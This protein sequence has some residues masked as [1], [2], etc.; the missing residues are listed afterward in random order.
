MSVMNNIRNKKM[1]ET[2]LYMCTR[3][4]LVIIIMELPQ[5]YQMGMEILRRFAISAATSNT[6]DAKASMMFISASVKVMNPGCDPMHLLQ[7]IRGIQTIGIFDANLEIAEKRVVGNAER[8]DDLH[9]GMGLRVTT[10]VEKDAIV[11]LYPVDGVGYVR[12]NKE[13]ENS[14]EVVCRFGVPLCV[15]DTIKDDQN[16]Y[17]IDLTT[18]DNPAMKVGQLDVKNIFPVVSLP[19]DKGYGGFSVGGDKYHGHMLNDYAVDLN[20]HGIPTIFDGCVKGKMPTQKQVNVWTKRY[21][22]AHA[23]H[24]NCVILRLEDTCVMILETTKPVAANTPLGVAY[25][26]Q[27]WLKYAYDLFPDEDKG[28]VLTRMAT[29]AMENV[30]RAKLDEYK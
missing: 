22:A 29:I 20:E 18:A 1:I 16:R 25:G 4:R 11:A 19:R 17:S 5:T 8:F 12:T 7:L 9:R 30:V 3:C 14:Y 10:S 27:Y 2:C 28:L 26:L 21:F 13:G 15:S 23:K 24:N 6:N